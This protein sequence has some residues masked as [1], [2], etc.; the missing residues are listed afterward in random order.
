M[1]L[2]RSAEALGVDPDK[3]GSH[4]LRFGGATALYAAYQDTGLVQR[5]G[6]WSSGAFQG[7]L[8][9]SK[10]SMKGVSKAMAKVTVDMI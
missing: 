6:R 9:E 4:S 10:E 3:I 2:E 7:Y 5:W 1:I 8:W